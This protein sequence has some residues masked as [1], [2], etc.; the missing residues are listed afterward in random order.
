M[1]TIRLADAA[2]HY[3]Q[4]PHQI[5]AWNALQE[6]L[7]PKQLSD[8]AE[9]YRAAPKP[10]QALVGNAWQRVV[11]VAKAAGA[12][13]PE[14][15]AAQW[16]LES[17]WGKHTSGTHN[18]FGLKGVGSDV[19]TKEFVNG[20]WITITA[21]FI[22]FPDLATCVQ[23]LVDRWYKDYKKFQGVNRAPDRNA[24]ARQLSKE[25]YATDPTYPEKLIRL[26][27]EQG[28]PVVKA[29]KFTPGSPF[30]YKLTPNI[31]YGEIALNSEARRFKAQYQCDTAM[32]L[33]QFAQKARDHFKRPVIITS[34]YR[35]AAINAQVGGASSSEHLYDAKDKGGLDFYLDGMSVKTLQD[36]CDK[37]WPHSLGY[38]APKGFVHVGMR[39]GRPR[40]RWDY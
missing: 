17:G 32:I 39:P 1:T 34:G 29:P 31:T 26:M 20:K 6:G 38:G 33:A 4:Q 36:W 22:N 2:K 3:Q 8:F 40:V 5:A 9:L 25:G 11:G 24:A 23:Y 18:Y 28:S 21:G 19:E 13:Y 27:D 35:P 12:K 15:V 14:L 16:A 10:K 30:A 7:T 37:E